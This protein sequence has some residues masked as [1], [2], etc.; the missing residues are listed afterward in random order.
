MSAGRL[1]TFNPAAHNF[2]ADVDKE[3][4]TRSAGL[5]ISAGANQAGIRRLR[6]IA[7]THTDPADLRS[8]LA[9]FDGEHQ[10][11]DRA[12]ESLQRAIDNAMAGHFAT[13]ARIEAN[14][15]A[16]LRETASARQVMV[17]LGRLPRTHANAILTATAER[18]RWPT[19][20]TMAD[21]N[22]AVLQPIDFRRDT[23][24]SLRNRHDRAHAVG[25]TLD[26]IGFADRPLG[27]A[28]RTV[29]A[30]RIARAEREAEREGASETGLWLVKGD[31]DELAAVAKRRARAWQ[32]GYIMSAA[33]CAATE[34]TPWI[35]AEREC[36]T[37]HKRLLRR[38]VRTAQG[39]LDC[40]L[41]MARPSSP[42]ISGFT[43][44]SWR[45]H[46]DRCREWSET[47]G[48]RFS[49]GTVVPLTT[50]QN[51]S[52][53]ARR[54]QLYAIVKGME[55]FGNVADYTA[56]FITLT[57]P[58]KYHSF[59]TGKQAKDGTY[60]DAKP[61]PGWDPRLG[62]VAQ[63]KE[64]QRRWA[65]LR[66][67]M[68]KTK[69]WRDYFGILVPEPH[70][71]GTPHFHAMLWMPTRFIRR[72]RIRQTE[73]ALRRILREI[74]PDR[75]GCLKAIRKS[76]PGTASPA[77]YV[78]KY[79]MESLDDESTLAQEGE[80]GE[81]HRAWASTRGIR[82]MRLIG[83]H[84][85]L[86]IWQ[87]L[88]TSSDDEELPPLATAAR[89]AMRRSAAAGE[90]AVALPQGS[91]ERAQARSE[92]A[93]ASADALSLIGGLPD[94]NANRR[95]KLG[96]EDGTTQYG[97]PTRKPVDILEQSL[98]K[99]RGQTRAQWE[100]IDRFPLR[101]QEAELVDLP[102]VQ[103]DDAQTEDS[104]VDD[105]LLKNNVVTVVANCPR[106]GAVAPSNETA[107]AVAKTLAPL[108]AARQRLPQWQEWCAARCDYLARLQGPPPQAPPPKAR[109][110]LSP[111]NDPKPLRT[112]ARSAARVNTSGTALRTAR[113]HD[114]DAGPP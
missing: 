55:H 78:M 2:T 8:I 72:G 102:R 61:N 107:E 103:P 73:H 22:G 32:A 88:W 31:E 68:A 89:A 100:T 11:K 41:R 91:V 80:A 15:E 104:L 33:R 65:L 95:L 34:R 77:S 111:N 14:T 58:G 114:P 74:A 64:L 18:E 21:L 4:T 87:R 90:R 57:L 13:V 106:D 92:Q 24:D 70:Q 26:Q 46:R 48:V 113:K 75:E 43:L 76:G 7:E 23:L 6:R 53:A 51:H 44:A 37:W 29:A 3:A 82:R 62:P 101:G 63:L 98:Q 52:R 12:E 28:C 16:L 27:E 108:I 94:R 99:A 71:N 45:Q 69:E 93:K 97:R 81:R 42:A 105:N 83:A 84:G 54:A 1:G 36:P 79:V 9:V 96:Y 38:E 60:P 109:L 10:D 67:R 66:S 49:D 17:G 86:R 85:S 112:T 5:R 110:R 40:T 30:S 20:P 50:I 19:V 59:S 35:R 47:Q 39:W 56:V 25:Q